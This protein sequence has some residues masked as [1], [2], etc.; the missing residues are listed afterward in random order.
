MES[1]DYC[2]NCGKRAEYVIEVELRKAE[3]IATRSICESCLMK[4]IN[5][6]IEDEK[7][8]TNHE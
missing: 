1:E 7:R 5:S 3:S 6:M 4:L 8:R 2:F